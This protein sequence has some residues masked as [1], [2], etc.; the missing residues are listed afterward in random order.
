MKNP[1]KLLIL[2]FLL[3]AAVPAAAQT[4]TDTTDQ[5][6]LQVPPL[7]Q[8]PAPS[9]TPAQQTPAQS[10]QQQVIQPAQQQQP[11]T[12]WPSQDQTPVRQ[13]IQQSPMI[14]ERP[15]TSAPT[16]VK[17]NT[18][19]ISIDLIM[20]LY[21][22]DIDFDIDYSGSAGAG[23]S[24]LGKKRPSEQEVQKMVT[25]QMDTTTAKKN[26]KDVKKN[27]KEVPPREDGTKPY[28]PEDA[29]YNKAMISL[30]N[31]QQLFASRRYTEAL[32]EINRSITF[33]PNI[34]LSYS[35]KGSIHYMLRQVS[36]AKRSWERALE[37]DPTMDN[38]RAILLRMY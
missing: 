11:Q 38:V 32:A 6:E 21:N 7:D 14:E 13:Q 35:V 22:K 36:D 27:G 1:T 25:E 16:N 33:A 8:E 2:L 3:C 17:I 18:P 19:L 15:V 34:A 37:L 10:S 24:N 12:A 23:V 20:D 29:N 30:N 26:G 31:A 28:T 9:S 4:D 5:E